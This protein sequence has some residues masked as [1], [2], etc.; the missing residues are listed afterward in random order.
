MDTNNINENKLNYSIEKSNII[1]FF[2]IQYLQN[3]CRYCKYVIEDSQIIY[4]GW[5]RSFCSPSCRKNYNNINKEKSYQSLITEF[6]N[7]HC[8][9]EV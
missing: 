4:Y 1:G 5:N 7:R 6:I 2:N 3:E 9:F 8:C